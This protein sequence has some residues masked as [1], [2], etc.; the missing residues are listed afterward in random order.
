MR[1]AVY[2]DTFPTL[3]SHIV[4]VSFSARVRSFVLGTQ[5]FFLYTGTHCATSWK[6]SGS[7]PDGVIGV[8]HS[9]NP[10]GRTMA[11][12]STQ[13]LTEMSTRDIFW[14]VKAADA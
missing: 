8:F 12:E 11:L 9:H 6:V 4:E 14:V 5:V 2:L 13:R 10:S 3:M 1:L 7:I